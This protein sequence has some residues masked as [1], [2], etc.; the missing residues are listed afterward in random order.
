M[1]PTFET[2]DDLSSFRRV[3]AALWPRP[4][5]S[6]ILGTMDLDATEALAFL[7]VQRQTTGLKLTI[8]HLVAR[9]VALSLARHPELNAKVRF[10]GKIERRTRVDLFVQVSAEGGND[11]SGAR[12]EAADT[13]RLAAIAGELQQKARK[14]R[15]GS[16]EAFARSRSAMRALP[17]WLTRAALTVSDVL[18]NELHIDLPSQGMPVDP[19]G[20]AMITNVG[21]FGIDTGFAPLFPLARCPMLILVPEIRRRPWV[22]GEE[23]IPRPVLRLCATFDHR[24]IDGYHAGLIAR[25]LRSLLESPATLDDPA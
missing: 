21:S 4:D 9:A 16:D 17:W 3:A 23:V 24:I 1:K 18:T 12:I 11:L 22:V 6:T 14:I 25:D 13:K 20:S 15:E 10:W 8:T 2:P 5:Q 19:F 7:E